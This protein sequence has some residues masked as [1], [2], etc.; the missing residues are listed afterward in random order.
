LAKEEYGYEY[1]SFERFIGFGINFLLIEVFVEMKSKE[2]K[3]QNQIR[4]ESKMKE[5]KKEEIKKKSK[6][7]SEH[8]FK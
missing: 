6:A 4:K 2:K 1:E 3:A 7:Y 8:A 5:V